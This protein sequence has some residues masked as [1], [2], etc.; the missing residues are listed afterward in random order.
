LTTVKNSKVFISYSHDSDAHMNRVFDLSERLRD[1]GV[2]CEIDQYET[3]PAGGQ[4]G[5]GI[6]SEMLI[7]PRQAHENYLVWV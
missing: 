5:P 2:D 3:S 4:G 6:R 1:E 7:Y